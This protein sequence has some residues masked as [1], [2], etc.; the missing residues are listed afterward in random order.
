MR[1]V[2]VF[3]EGIED[4]TMFISAF[5]FVQ[6]DRDIGKAQNKVKETK[7]AEREK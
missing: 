1:P 6:V 5:T 3:Y 7:N 4:T 2:T